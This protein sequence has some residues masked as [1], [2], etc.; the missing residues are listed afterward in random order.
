[1]AAREAGNRIKTPVVLIADDDLFIRNLLKKLVP[2]PAEFIEVS[3]G[4]CVC[5]AYKQHN[6]LLVFLD[7]HM[8]GADGIKIVKDLLAYDSKAYIVIISADGSRENVSASVVSGAKCFLGK[9]LDP[10]R[11]AA[12]VKNA[13]TQKTGG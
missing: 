7:M 2:E 9:P 11:V 3:D 5:D 4:T 6:P 8:P 10:K 12:E 13:L 1:M